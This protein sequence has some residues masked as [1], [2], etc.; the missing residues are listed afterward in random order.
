ML[1][2]RPDRILCRTDSPNIPYAR[3]RELRRL[4][5]ARPERHHEALLGGVARGLFGIG[6]A[7]A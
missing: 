6:N 2:V 5:R 3:D 1:D 7:R 4:L